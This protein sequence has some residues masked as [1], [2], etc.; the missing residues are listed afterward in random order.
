MNNSLFA[1]NLFMPLSQ[2]VIRYFKYILNMELQLLQS[3]ISDGPNN[4]ELLFIINEPTELDICCRRMYENRIKPE[5]LRIMGYDDNNDINLLK[6]NTLKGHFENKFRIKKGIDRMQIHFFR[7][8]I[9][10]FFKGHGEQ[11]L[12]NC[13]TYVTYYLSNYSDLVKIGDHTPEKLHQLFLLPGLQ[14]WVEFVRRF[15]KYAPVLYVRGWVSETNTVEKLMKIISTDLTK[16]DASK[17]FVIFELKSISH[18]K[19]IVTILEELA[20]HAD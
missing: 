19:E 6:F 1:G 14:N 8:Q 5:K 12:M 17:P 20:Q 10:L 9:N 11:S 2:S 18:I 16:I 15:N 3:N 7:D 4:I 13:L